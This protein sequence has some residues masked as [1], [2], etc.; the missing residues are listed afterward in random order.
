M[1]F[2][3][4]PVVGDVH[5]YTDDRGRKTNFQWDG[6]SWNRMDDPPSSPAPPR[7][8]LRRI[9]GGDGGRP[10]EDYEVI[11]A[12]GEKVGRLYRAGPPSAAA[13]VELTVYGLVG[14]TIR[15]P[16]A[17]PDAPSRAGGGSRPRAM[18][19]SCGS[20]RFQLRRRWMRKAG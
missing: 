20:R 18:S 15:Q 5:T 2:P 19:A 7:L 1:N 9:V 16:A 14:T 8:E 10:R 12:R 3:A 6:I 11:D 4:D 13:C 17:G